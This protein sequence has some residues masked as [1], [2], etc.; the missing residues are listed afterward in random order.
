TSARLTHS[1]SVCGTQPIFGAI[2]STA[3]QSDGYS[4]R[5]SC[6]SRTARSRTSGENLF[7][8][9][10][11]PFSQIVEPPRNP[12]RF[13]LSFSGDRYRLESDQSKHWPMVSLGDQTLFRIESGGTPKSGEP[14]Y[15]SGGVPWATLVDIPQSDFITQLTG[16]E[17]TI[18]E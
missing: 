8:L 11:A 3:A 6:T 14:T 1:S 4:P 18:S 10:M 15:W 5:C 7:D 9:V 2:D 12:G 13:K 16:T 17:R